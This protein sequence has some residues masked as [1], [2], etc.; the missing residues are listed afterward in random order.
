MSIRGGRLVGEWCSRKCTGELAAEIPARQAGK[1]E[2]ERC[3]AT[4]EVIAQQEC[5][6]V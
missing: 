2:M 4:I 3:A 6:G 1:E 5:A